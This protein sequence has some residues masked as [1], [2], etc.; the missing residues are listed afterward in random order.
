MFTFRLFPSLVYC[1]GPVTQPALRRGDCVLL[2]ECL[3]KDL[4]REL[5]GHLVKTIPQAGWA[6]I[7][8]GKLLPGRAAAGVVFS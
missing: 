4:A 6:S 3:P 7:S 5:P 8:N 2:D 1:P